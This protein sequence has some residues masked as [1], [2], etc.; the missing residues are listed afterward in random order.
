MQP[1]AAIN[2]VFKRLAEGKVAGRVVLN[3]SERSFQ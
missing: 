2:D 3:F 1:L